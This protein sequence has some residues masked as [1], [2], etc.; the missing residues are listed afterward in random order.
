M[1]R[2]GWVHLGI[3]FFSITLGACST[4]PTKTDENGEVIG[5]DEVPTDSTHHRGSSSSEDGSSGDMA[6]SADM[7]TVQSGDTL[8]KIAFEVY[9]NVYQWK[10]LYKL[11]KHHISDPN[12]IQAGSQLKIHR[13]SSPPSIESHGEKYLIKAGDTLGIISN[14]LYATP[15]RWKEIWEN[16]KK[17]IPNPDQIFSGFYLYYLPDSGRKH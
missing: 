17:L 15:S 10:A 1:Q 6:G 5:T 3:L 16:N 2:I 11:N 12:H 4:S 7:I 13:P 8:M 9:G 14:Q